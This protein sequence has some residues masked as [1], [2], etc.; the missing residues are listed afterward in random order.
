MTIAPRIVVPLLN[1]TSIFEASR[2][3]ATP[4][5]NIR[6]VNV[7]GQ[8]TL[9]LPLAPGEMMRIPAPETD[10][11]P[12]IPNVADPLNTVIRGLLTVPKV[13][14]PEPLLYPLAY[15]V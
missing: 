1:F 6:P 3:P 9:N 13:T 15:V 2:P 5:T 12:L 14:F 4:T 8:L 7:K 10:P 11:A